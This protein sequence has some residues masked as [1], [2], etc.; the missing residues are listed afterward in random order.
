[1]QVSKFTTITVMVRENFIQ[2]SSLERSNYILFLMNEE[3]WK[4]GTDP[5]HTCCKVHSYFIF[6]FN[7]LIAGHKIISLLV[8]VN[9][10]EYVTIWSTN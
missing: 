5:I 4:L 6:L 3:I 8:Q 7:L 2:N 10:N 1:M 9:D